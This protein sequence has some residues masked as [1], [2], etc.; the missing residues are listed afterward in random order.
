MT[1][2]KTIIAGILV[3]ILILAIGYFLKPGGDD[4]K[5]TRNTN[6][7]AAQTLRVAALEEVSPF[8]G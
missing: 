6:G 1:N 4:F 2:K 8:I 5:D 3:F 7:A